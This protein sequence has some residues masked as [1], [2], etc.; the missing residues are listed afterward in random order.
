MRSN[1]LVRSCSKCSDH[2]TLALYKLY[3]NS[4]Y[5]EETIKNKLRKIVNSTVCLN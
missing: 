3:C 4:M 2:V 1:V 5:Y